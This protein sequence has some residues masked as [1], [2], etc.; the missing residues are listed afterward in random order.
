M[1]EQL[2]ISKDNKKIKLLQPD[3]L[4]INLKENY[5]PPY[6]QRTIKLD[7]SEDRTK[8]HSNL[9]NLLG[10]NWIWSGESCAEFYA[11]TTPTRTFTV[12]T[13]GSNIPYYTI[14]DISVRF[15]NYKVSLQEKSKPEGV[16]R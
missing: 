16:T 7:L 1:E 3:K 4:L 13:R 14:D 11:A 10:K 2:I 6:V 9:D 5:I 8:A 15:Y 12:F